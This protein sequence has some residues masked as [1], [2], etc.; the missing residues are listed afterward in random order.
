LNNLLNKYR[1]KG[2]RNISFGSLTSGFSLV[3]SLLLASLITNNYGLNIYGQLSILIATLSSADLITRFPTTPISIRYLSHFLKEKK[4]SNFRGVLVLELVFQLITSLLLFIL[5]FLVSP[6]LAEY[7]LK[8]SSLGNLFIYYYFITLFYSLRSFINSYFNVFKKFKSVF[9]LS[10]FENVF[11]L[12]GVFIYIKISASRD[13]SS[14]IIVYIITSGLVFLI[15]FI[16]FLKHFSK[17]ISFGKIDFNN[18]NINQ[19][20]KFSSQ[21]FLSSTLK[22]FHSKFPELFLSYFTDASSVG[23]YSIYKKIPS[24][25]SYYTSSLSIITYPKIVD[26]KLQNKL[27]EIKKVLNQYNFEII[28]L[29]LGLAFFTIAFSGLI[30]RFFGLENL[31]NKIF[32]VIFLSNTILNLNW[33]N[34][35][36][37]EA[38]ETKLT[39]KLH[40]LIFILL[41]VT[42]PFFIKYFSLIGAFGSIALVNLSGVLYVRSHANKILSY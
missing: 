17:E 14:I 36:Y 24:I 5:I 11:K 13:I 19:Y 20:F 23:L 3:L 12:I 39:I 18:F 26:L 30:A 25:L 9:L 42:L 4:Y 35:G 22:G 7:V 2:Y 21:L 38:F 16:Y 15:Y 32:Y 10:F 1:G 31:D 34:K 27:F 29:N 6:G 41:I 40:L 8:D 28:I 37:S 33:W